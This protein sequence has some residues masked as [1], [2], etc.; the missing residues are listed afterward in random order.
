MN[1]LRRAAFRLHP[2]QRVL[3]ATILDLSLPNCRF[4]NLVST[5]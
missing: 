4:A 5:T 1:V 2:Y 3:E